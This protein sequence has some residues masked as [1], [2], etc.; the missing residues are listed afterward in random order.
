MDK[1]KPIMIVANNIEIQLFSD[2]F[3]QQVIMDSPILHQFKPP[4]TRVEKDEFVEKISLLIKTGEYPSILIN[5]PQDSSNLLLV[6]EKSGGGSFIFIVCDRF[7]KEPNGT[8][9]KLT[10]LV[11]NFHYDPEKKVFVTREQTNSTMFGNSVV[12][13]EQ[14]GSSFNPESA[15]RNKVLPRVI[16]NLIRMKRY[17][18]DMSEFL[19]HH[20][21]TMK[22]EGSRNLYDALF[23]Y[24]REFISLSF[25]DGD[26]SLENGVLDIDSDLQPTSCAVHKIDLIFSDSRSRDGKRR[27]LFPTSPSE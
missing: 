8:L 27:R 1:F 24:F 15:P 17:W 26:I 13:V 7:T 5:T 3:I 6:Y 16:F 25:V 20:F 19:L 9:V 11:N 22:E 4:L 18:G 23:A 21:R 10:L 12:K 2:E 14:I